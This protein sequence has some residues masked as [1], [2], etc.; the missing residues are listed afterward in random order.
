[1]LT[2]SAQ[3]NLLLLLAWYREM[4]VD[5]AVSA[6]PIDWLTRGDAAARPCG[7]Q[8]APESTATA[9][10]ASAIA[11][12]LG[13]AATVRQLAAMPPEQL[14]MA[15]RAAAG[16][17]QS[18]DELHAILAGFDGCSLRTTARN[19]CFYRGAKGARLVLIGEAPG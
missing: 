10:Q 11:S 12:Q 7:V 16:S 19:L 14:T 13:P 5:S 17:A 2:T 1:M 9:P 3:Q 15:A 4:G 8:G 6:T 18:L